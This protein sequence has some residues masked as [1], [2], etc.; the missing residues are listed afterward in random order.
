MTITKRYEITSIGENL[1]KTELLHT[2]GGNVYLGNFHGKPLGRFLMNFK[3]V[4]LCDPL[5]LLLGIYSKEIQSLS[6]SE[7]C[8]PMFIAALFTAVS[9]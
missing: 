5:I 2:V 7:I 6:Q 4:L 1:E 3:R 8:T 9:V